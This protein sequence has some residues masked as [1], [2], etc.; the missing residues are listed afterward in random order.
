[1][2]NLKLKHWIILVVSAITIAAIIALPICMKFMHDNTPEVDTFTITIEGFGEVKADADGNYILTSPNK[3]GYEFIKWTTADGEEFPASGKISSDLTVVPVFSIIKTTTIEQL[4]EYAA[5]GAEKIFIDADIVI[6]RPIFIVD[7]TTIY[8]EKDVK[9]TRSPDYAGDIFVVGISENEEPSVL[10]GKDAVLTFEIKDGSLTIDG[11]RDNMNVT[12]VGSAIFVTDSA[13]VN[14]NPGVIIANN[15]KDGNERAYTCTRWTGAWMADRAGGAAILILNGSVNM[16]GGIIENNWVRSEVTYKTNEDGT[17][18]WYEDAGCGGAIYNCGNFNMYGGIIRNSEALVGGAIYNDEI[19]RLVAGEISGN[20]SHS[21]GGAV[22]SS[23]SY[24]AEM[25]IGTDKPSESKMIFKGNTADNGGALFS[26]TDSPIVITGNTVFEGN[27]SLYGGGAIYTAGGLTV[28]GT[29][30]IGN[31]TPNGGGAIYFHYNFKESSKKD[32]RHLELTGCTFK[33]NRAVTGGA[34]YLSASDDAKAKEEGAY[35]KITDCTFD[36]NSADNCGALY[37]TRFGEAT[38]VNSAFK[39]NSTPGTGGAITVQAGCTLTC[40]SVSF[41]NNSAAGAGALYIYDADSVSLTKVIFTGNTATSGNGG[42]IYLNAI[43]LTLG[44]GTLFKNNSASN[45]GGAIYASYITRAENDLDG[46][47]LVIDGAAFEGN[48]ALYGGAI[49]LRTSGIANIKN[50]SFKNNT[51][52][53]SETATDM[54]GGAIFSDNSTIKIKDSI[55]EGSG[56]GYKGGALQLQGCNTTIEGTTFS[57]GK[58]ENG[59]A[60][61]AS[62]GALTVKT[63]SFNNNTATYGG[64]IF[65]IGD[66]KVNVDNSLFTAN[67]A[68]DGGAIYAAR[69]EITVSG[70]NTAF[71]DNKADR[72]GAVYLTNQTVGEENIGAS[73]IMTG[74]KFENNEATVDGGAISIRS[75]C[76]AS[77]TST[78]F[79]ANKASGIDG[80]QGGGAIYVGWGTLNLDSVT[81]TANKVENGY[82]GAV[83]ANNATFTVT[84]KTVIVGNTVENGENSTASNVYLSKGKHITIA[85]E[86]EEGSLIG[87]TVPDGA[88]ASGDGE[89][90]TDVS[91]Y[92]DFFVS[93]E[94]KPIYV[95]DNMLFVG[96]LITV[97][98]STF[99]DFTVESTSNT[100]KWYLI[101]D[102][103]RENAVC[104]G[105]VLTGV[106]EGKIYVCVVSFG[107]L[108]LETVPVIYHEKQSHPICGANCGHSGDDAHDSHSFRP[109]A[110]EAELIKALSL[111]GSYYLACD[112]EISN[113]LYVEKEINLCLN[114]KI[115]S[116][117]SGETA[118]TMI[119]AKVALTIADCSDT[120][121]VGYIDPTTGLWVEGTLDGAKAV[122]LKGGIIMGGHGQ[123]GGAINATA[124]VELYGINLINN[125]ATSDGGAIYLSGATL[126]AENCSFV[127]NSAANHA[128]AVYVVSG[129]TLTMKDG[130]FV[131]NK[132]LDGGAVNIRSGCTAT[133]TN[134]IFDSNIATGTEETQGGGAIYVGWGT[135]ALESITMT[136]NSVDGGFGGAI[137]ANNSDITVI[138]GSLEE[139][140]AASGGAIYVTVNNDQSKS[141]SISGTEFKSNNATYGGAIYANSNAAINLEDTCFEG[142][143]A[144]DGGAI[145][146]AGAVVNANGNSLF[147]SNSANRGGAVYLTKYG[148]VGGAITVNGGRFEN[149]VGSVDGGAISIRTGASATLVSTVFDGNSAGGSGVWQCGGAIYSG[150]GI[151]TLDSVTMINNTVADGGYGSAINANGTTFNIKGNI[152]IVGNSIYLHGSQMLNIVG[153]LTSGAK[154]QVAVDERAFAEIAGADITDKSIYGAFFVTDAGYTVYEKDGKLYA[155]TTSLEQPDIWNNF[156]VTSTADSYKWYL[157]SDVNREN[158]LCE[159]KTL[160]GVPEGQRYVCVLSFGSHKIE[161]DTVLYYARQTHPA[162]GNTCTH[163][164]AHEDLV[165]IPVATEAELIK[166][167]SLGGSYYLACDIEISNTLYVE[168][169][170]IL[171]LNGKILSAK[172]GETAF[173]MIRAKVT[174][175]IAD[176][177]DTE[178]VGYIDP[179]TG[180]WVEGTLDGAKA[181]T[182]KGGIIMGGHGQW[183]GAINATA[184]VEL[185]G[186]NL[187]NNNATSDGGA[188]YLSGATLTAENCSFVGNSAA[189][190]AGAVYV[191]SGSTLTMK[192]GSF[193]G[194]KALDGGAVNIRSG[195]TA[196]FTNT[197][198]DSNIATG[199]EETQGGG[200]I[201][202]GWGTLALESITMTGN[203]V[204]GG[205]GGAINANNSD[206]TVIGGSLEENSAANGGAIYVTVNSDQ[207]KTASISG[208]EFNSNTATNGGAIAIA[209]N[210]TTVDSSSF[211]DNSATTYGG[212]IYVLKCN[213]VIKNSTFTTN[214]APYGGAIATLSELTTEIQSSTFNGNTAT[215][216]GAIYAG[217]TTVN[218]SGN[219]V[220]TNNSA[221]KGGAI[222][223]GKYATNGASLT[224][225]GGRFEGNK[226][227]VDGGAI[228]I[229]TGSSATLISTILTGNSAG[230]SG[231]WQCGGAIYSG[232]GSLTL[233][234]VTMTNNT[235]AD[236][237]YGSAINANGTTF[238]I[239]GKLNIANNAIYLHSTQQMIITG[240]IEKGSVI[241]IKPTANAFAKGDGAN[242]TD[243]SAYAKYFICDD[244]QTAY[245]K[246]GL[247]YV[248]HSH[249]A[250]GNECTHGSHSDLDFSPVSNEA[251]LREALIKGGNYYLTHDIEISSVITTSVE[252][253]LCLNGKILFAKSGD[254]AFTMIRAKAPLTITDCSDI[255]RVGYIDPATDL[256]VEGTLDGAEAITLKGGIIMGAHGQWGGA[257]NATAAVELYNVNLVNNAVTSQGGA[258]Y[259]EGINVGIHNVTFVANSA[260]ADGGAIYL[261]AAN[262]IADGSTRFLYNSAGRGGA[263]Y[264]VQKDSIAATLSM[265]GGS[266]VGNT[267]TGDGGAIHA[268]STCKVSFTSTVF[269]NNTATGSSGV[270]NAGGGAIFVSWATLN[271]DSV[272]MT[273]NSITN[274]TGEAVHSDNSK[275]TVLYSTES[276]KTALDSVIKGSGPSHKLTFTQK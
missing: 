1:M 133:F 276:E 125:N 129:S 105:N 136:G 249:A 213:A 217:S 54:G 265:T 139:N 30:F 58:S 37:V 132:A 212:A 246:D 101:D 91:I 234:G 134:T 46:A 87:I 126:T 174:L 152:N 26:N 215:Q 238:T 45:Q 109:I 57:A 235:V 20:I 7:T 270:A 148:S 250:C 191:V 182:L 178:R 253:N 201:Y 166:A 99:N 80:A 82:G 155:G 56:S 229:R 150:N 79:N 84:G 31:T 242:V 13:V 256:W 123:W 83:N 114:G 208:A 185:Y 169:E 108:N 194:N 25:Y 40:N 41:E 121:R 81:M 143:K 200:A 154:I 92:K 240:A 145:Y 167:L 64:A 226:G 77:L 6:D 42:A 102:E 48:K 51:T 223:L 18:S 71:A 231:V 151:L 33:D 189:N 205:F 14:I 204:D 233:D 111:G 5:G 254:T 85:G 259:A 146:I 263:V 161:T 66:L 268:R 272:T 216:A 39:N 128:G 183:G 172:S 193:V 241:T 130:S 44:E 17:T 107:D 243:V 138:G 95:D 197:I 266:F 43:K 27:S 70:S 9:L 122:T 110:T 181:V 158:V 63:S 196:T 255:E 11:N 180:L 230:G 160:T 187:I 36:G 127:G 93:D 271:L 59:G 184:K 144:N 274:G 94:G 118:F 106:E 165:F 38:V 210:G 47:E 24:E 119:R 120:E 257:I 260:A 162:C 4:A 237:G 206:I 221:E 89:I 62:H 251:E 97:Q 186:I 227:T 273:G 34:V 76:S 29:E 15:K 225:N 141:A 198:F 21:K 55:F 65:G 86:L 220:F 19:V 179:T 61:Y 8:V 23:S 68:A 224:V 10:E 214:N 78:V 199:T 75:N 49:S 149:N 228:S 173:T 202:V 131:G 3:T 168:K 207:N 209:G 16:Y 124:K 116:A 88:F 28:R 163:S 267:A 262:T 245:E 156:T 261:K 170:I 22:A 164:G 236:G 142:N 112:I 35:A 195:C 52:L 177:S 157:A 258:L 247:L 60:I 137:N 104:E 192:D 269:E 117:K 2:K 264:L 96:L 175:T 203:S 239:K 248:G 222:Y 115:L 218:V 211:E 275:V 252:V 140:S 232:G 159:G 73:L 90:I 53:E 12:V 147:D 190:H 74:G 188:I 98:P 135:L 244:G 153:A 100:Y 72:G 176:C 50:A 219:S 32:T 171:C 69:A 103:S 67:E 113:T